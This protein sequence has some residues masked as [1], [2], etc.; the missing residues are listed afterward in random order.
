MP[1]L[2]I[3]TN[4]PAARI[5]DEFVRRASRKAAE[6]TELP[7]AVI[8]VVVLA[9]QKISFGGSLEPSAFVSLHHVRAYEE[10]EIRRLVHSL[11]A[12]LEAEL[13]VDG[14]RIFL[15]FEA[16]DPKAVA[17]GRRLVADLIAEMTA[18]AAAGRPPK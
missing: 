2:H 15:T 16:H 9:D 12:F 1:I 8:Q 14:E 18:A 7:E 10:A 17:R 6:L 11:V 5:D 4:L 3:S 13:Q